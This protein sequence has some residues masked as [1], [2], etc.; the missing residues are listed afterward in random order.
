[1]PICS[2]RSMEKITMYTAAWCGD[3]R[4]AKRHLVEKGIPFHEIDIDEHPEAVQTVVAARGKR[5][6]PTLEY[7]G[8]FIDGNHFNVEKFA[9]DLAE[10]LA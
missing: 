8:K 3:C 1:M 6:L 4:A 5:V 10:L 2:N 9:K 7:N